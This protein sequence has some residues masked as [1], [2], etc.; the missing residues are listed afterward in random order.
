[1]EIK[2]NSWL[3]YCH[4]LP[5]QACKKIWNITI[6]CSC[7]PVEIC[8]THWGQRSTYK[9]TLTTSTYF[10][11]DFSSKVKVAVYSKVEIGKRLKLKTYSWSYQNITHS[12]PEIAFS[13]RLVYPEIILN[14]LH[15]SKQI[16]ETYKKNSLKH[17]FPKN[18]YRSTVKQIS[19]FKKEIHSHS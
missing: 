13:L 8:L 15:I 16:L 2:L 1:M 6:R 11:D 4:Q 10:I 7:E 9:F 3:S 5:D 12:R 17:H 14:R 18:I 19:R